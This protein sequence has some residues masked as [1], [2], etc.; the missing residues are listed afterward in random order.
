MD[1][2]NS[3]ISIYLAENY[4]NIADA[5]NLAKS[6]TRLYF[7]PTQTLILKEGI[8]FCVR[9]GNIELLDKF[10]KE[11]IKPHL[12]VIAIHSQQ[13]E[14]ANWI[15]QHLQRFDFISFVRCELES[16]IEH[17]WDKYVNSLLKYDN[18]IFSNNCVLQHFINTALKHSNLACVQNICTSCDILTTNPTG[19]VQAALHFKRYDVLDWL[20]LQQVPFKPDSLTMFYWRYLHICVLVIKDLINQKTLSYFHLLLIFAQICIYGI[21]AILPG[22]L[23]RI[24]LTPVFDY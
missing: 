18:A 7:K 3:D 20:S 2:L 14:T 11:Q 13:F 6:S 21:I 9:T 17:N 5:G 24:L 10:P 16:A 15:K 1:S 19:L 12:L 22:I 8:A 4:L 23:I